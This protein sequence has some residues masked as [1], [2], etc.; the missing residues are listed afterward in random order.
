MSALNLLERRRAMIGGVA[1]DKWI[2]YAVYVSSDGS[3]RAIFSGDIALV[4]RMVLDGIEITPIASKTFDTA[5]TYSVDI[6]LANPATIPD[7]GFNAGHYRYIELPSCV[8]YIDTNAFRNYNKSSLTC[9]ATT[10]PS[11]NGD[12]FYNSHTIDVYVPAGTVTA[13]Q[14]AWSQM[15]N[16]RAI[17]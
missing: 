1:P 15:T 6:L 16:I 10:P 13:Y 5:G 9:H 12:P 14:S 11:L 4:D 17:Q 3:S 7:A 8:T 2:H